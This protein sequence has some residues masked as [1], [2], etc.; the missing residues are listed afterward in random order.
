MS[1]GIRI[2]EAGTSA[3]QAHIGT[4]SYTLYP[5]LKL[6][7]TTMVTTG[8]ILLYFVFFLNFLVVFVEKFQIGIVQYYHI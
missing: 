1:V 5:A 7:I 6:R 4:L 2:S 8:L 3:I